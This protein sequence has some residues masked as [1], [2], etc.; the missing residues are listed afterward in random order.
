[1]TDYKYTYDID[2]FLNDQYD[3]SKLDTE[4]RA[5]AIVTALS[6]LSGGEDIVDIYFKA[7]LSS[8]DWSTLSGVVAAH[9]GEDDFINYTPV[10]L[11]EIESGVEQSVILSEEYRDPSGK[12][13]VH[14]TS[15]KIGLMTHWT[16]KGDNPTDVTD[17]GNGV[18]LALE[19]NIGG[20]N[21]DVVYIDFNCIENETWMHEG[22]LTWN[23]AEMDT[24]TAEVV[25][26]TVKY[27]FPGISAPV[28][29]GDALDDCTSSGTYTG[30]TS[31]EYI[32]Q[33]DAEGTPDTFKWSNNNGDGWT[34]GVAITGSMQTLSSGVQVSFAATT[35]HTL[36]DYW[37][38]NAVVSNPTTYKLYGYLVVPSYFPYGTPIDVISDLTSPEMDTEGFG[39]LVYM[40]TD[41]SGAAPMSFWNADYNSTTHLFENIT[42]APAGDGSYN[43]FA[44][45]ILFTRFFNSVPLASNGTMCYTSSDSE[46]IGHGMRLKVS[47]ATNVT[48]VPDHAW[49]AACTACLHRDKTH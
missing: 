18:S 12:L 27:G 47:L 24:I 42:P 40:P 48:S 8:T 45:E 22:Y 28:F 44:S 46:C 38:V 5:S 2:Q 11:M 14:Q 29:Y 49:S 33:I 4:I 7:Q 20:N 39:G 17:V 6:Y 30:L 34:E 36:G 37:C 21:P 32:I 43:I 16:G 26:R 3:L 13:R 15:R 35:G 10:K 25:P 31:K 41:E 1:M 9:D 23:D 19:H